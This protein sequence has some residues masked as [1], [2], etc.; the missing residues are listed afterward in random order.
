MFKELKGLKEAPKNAMVIS[1]IALSVA[2]VALL[3][4]LGGRHAIQS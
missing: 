2:I 1:C 3:V 4:S